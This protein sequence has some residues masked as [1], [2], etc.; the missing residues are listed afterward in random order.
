MKIKMRKKIDKIFREV[1]IQ[2]NVNKERYYRCFIDNFQR[3]NDPD[4]QVGFT[5]SIVFN[6][7]EP[8]IKSEIDSMIEAKS[9]V[10]PLGD[11]KWVHLA[12]QWLLNELQWDE[13][14]IN[15][16]DYLINMITTPPPS[17]VNTIVNMTFR[18]LNFSMTPG[19]A[20]TNS[21]EFQLLASQFCKYYSHAQKHT[22]RKHPLEIQT[23]TSNSTDM[24]EGT[25]HVN[26]HLSF[27]GDQV[28]ELPQLLIAI[29]VENAHRET[30]NNRIALVV[31]PLFVFE[32][33]L[34]QDPTNS[35]VVTGG[36][37]TL[38][39]PSVSLLFNIKHVIAFVFL[40]LTRDIFGKDKV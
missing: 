2:G 11:K 4:T 24:F 27:R 23:L 6:G 9:S 39:T 15:I 5:Y 3:Q 13:V 20:D 22:A 18:L 29:L 19:L 31:G 28:P 36:G 17:Q 34:Q 40:E 1:P 32:D 7:T 33:S 10:Y 25:Q 16:S 30:I 8:L 12:D 37:T 14:K 21:A 26:F 35:I 38:S